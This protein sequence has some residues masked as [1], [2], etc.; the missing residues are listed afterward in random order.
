MLDTP[1]APTVTRFSFPKHTHP[2]SITNDRRYAIVVH[3]PSGTISVVGPFRPRSTLVAYDKHDLLFRGNFRM[4][5]EFPSEKRGNVIIPK[6]GHA[7]VFGATYVLYEW[8]DEFAEIA[9]HVKR[10][11]ATAQREAGRA[12]PDEKY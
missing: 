10:E 8:T 6:D 9:E 3:S 12:D 4:V 2:G 11:Q 1:T 7:K 5:A